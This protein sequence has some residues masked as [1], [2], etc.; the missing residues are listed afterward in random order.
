MFCTSGF[1]LI[2]HFF[3][4]IFDSRVLKREETQGQLPFCPFCPD[5]TGPADGVKSNDSSTKNAS[6]FFVIIFNFGV[7]ERDKEDRGKIVNLH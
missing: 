3:F 4:V 7:L 6:M 2:G 5:L 1:H